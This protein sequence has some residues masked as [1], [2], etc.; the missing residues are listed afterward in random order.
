MTPD[1][2]MAWVRQRTDGIPVSATRLHGGLMNHVHR[3]RLSSG[4]A[5]VVKRA[6]PHVAAAPE[7]PLAAERAELEARALRCVAGSQVPQLVD[8]HAHTLILEDI[9]DGPDL[10]GWLRTGGDPHILDRLAA[11]LR[12]LH[13]RPGPGFVNHD[14]Q[15]TR[16]SVQYRP[17][18]GWLDER[19]HPEARQAGRQALAVGTHLATPGPD[20]VMGDLWPPSVQVRPQRPGGFVVLDWEMATAGHR[21][22]DLGHLCAHLWLEQLVIGQDHG[23][24]R[25]FVDA[26]GPLPPRVARTAAQHQG[27]ELLARSI[28]GFARSDL[29][30][31]QIAPI[32]DQAVHLLLRADSPTE[33]AT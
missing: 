14:I 30:P 18:G 13:D 29:Q 1:Q 15:K 5:W 26:Y 27:C 3:V 33:P 6:P 9:G 8:I 11:W 19:G 10:A 7:I 28:G 24:I 25:R 21:A 16:L 4:K 12:R 2:A 31:G 20:F 32:I 23:W 17:L 22:Q